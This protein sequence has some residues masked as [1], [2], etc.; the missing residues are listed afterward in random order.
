MKIYVMKIDVKKNL[1]L[2]QFVCLL[3][4]TKTDIVIE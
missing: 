3:K 1:R 4:Q 2:K